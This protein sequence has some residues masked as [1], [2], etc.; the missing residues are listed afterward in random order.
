MQSDG[1]T[2]PIG[3]GL[4]RFL[5]RL[6]KAMASV[7]AVLALLTLIPLDFPFLVIVIA[8]VVFAVAV[9]TVCLYL[10]GRRQTIIDVALSLVLLSAVQYAAMAWDA[11]RARAL[12]QRQ[13]QPPQHA[14]RVVVFDWTRRSCFDQ[15]MELLAKTDYQPAGNLLET[16]SG[17]CLKR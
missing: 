8:I 5:W 7:V 6:A 1:E 16:G 11:Q 12:E 17:R 2:G 10:Q 9:L 15:C 13:I 14:Y 4:R 3:I